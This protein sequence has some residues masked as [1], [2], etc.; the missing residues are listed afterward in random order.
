MR[1]FAGSSR[2]RAA[3]RALL[4][5]RDGARKLT[6]VR[7]LTELLQT[8]EAEQRLAPAAL[9]VWFSRRRSDERIR[10]DETQL[11]IDSDEQLVRVTTVHGAKGLE[12]P[13]VF[14]PFAW[15]G[16]DPTRGRADHAAYHE[17][18][19]DGY[20]A[21]LDLDPDDAAKRAARP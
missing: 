20:P 8:A 3:A 12:F 13:A 4:R 11:R 10:D 5:Y 17:G 1:S 16:R 15:D 6:N 2:P 7:H 14:L 21:V 9:A 19:A 18:E